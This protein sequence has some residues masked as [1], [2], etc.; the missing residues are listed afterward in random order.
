MSVAAFQTEYEAEVYRLYQEHLPKGPTAARQ[1]VEAATVLSWEQIREIIVRVEARGPAN[2]RPRRRRQRSEVLESIEQRDKRLASLPGGRREGNHAPTVT[3]VS[4]RLDKDPDMAGQIR[5]CPVC[6][7]KFKI[8]RRDQITC[9]AHC[10]DVARRVRA[11]DPT[12]EA[13]IG[14][15]FDPPA[16]LG[17]GKPL[18]AMR[19]DAKYHGAA[20]RK[21][22]ERAK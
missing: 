17:C 4:K 16:C 18:W 1:A 19:P 12:V 22:H 13:S 21:K 9:D 11:N 20:C 3:E 5:E 6:R 2:G 14:M 7:R 15:M 8:G 10:R